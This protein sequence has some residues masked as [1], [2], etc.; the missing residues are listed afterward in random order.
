METKALFVDGLIDSSIFLQARQDPA[1]D[2]L[3]DPSGSVT[4]GELAEVVTRTSALL[5]RVGVRRGDRVI[6]AMKNGVRQLA[7]HFAV[8]HLGGVSVP[9]PPGS[10]TEQLRHCFSDTDATAI[11]VDALSEAAARDFLGGRCGEHLI[12]SGADVKDCLA[13]LD[14]V[15]GEAA[16]CPVVVGR[17]RDDLA[18]LMY[19]T[20][21]TG[22]PKA[23]MLSHRSLGNS[24]R[25][26]VEYVG[27][28]GQS[29]EGVVLPLSHSFGLGHVYCNLATGGYVWVDDGIKRVKRVLDALVSER[30]NGFPATPSM[31]NVL[32]TRYGEYF[33]KCA[34]KL[35]FM[36]VNSEPLPPATAVRLM[37]ELPN[38]RVLVYYGLTEASR[39]TFI[40]L[41]AVTKERLSSVGPASPNVE[42]NVRSEG[43]IA[44]P[45][46]TEGEIWIGGDHL[47]L[48]YWRR[49]SE[50]LETFVHGSVRTG[51]LGTADVEGYVTITGRLKDQINVGG[52]KVSAAQVER[53]IRT[54]GAVEDVAVAEIPDPGGVVGTVVGALLVS[55]EGDIEG[56][57]IRLHCRDALEPFMLPA[58]V[59][60]VSKIPRSETGKILRE[61]VVRLLLDGTRES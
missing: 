15:S 23:V 38:V 29:R 20:G 14:D 16:N 11:I 48:G 40:D 55:Q 43:G 13:S 61:E 33:S 28:R 46:G 49:E 32:L 17:S 39:S 24:L 7:T 41:S 19:T 47:A 18:C 50:T 2:A 60:C 36:V 57:E 54:H 4:Y 31:I 42:V 59:R 34:H 26:I 44:V 21:S 22:L 5:H 27:Y 1:R 12:S 45:P 25:N 6:V 52:L 58:V 8:L 51:D 3:G 10:R 30:L 37:E 35:E 9:L 53:A 56:R